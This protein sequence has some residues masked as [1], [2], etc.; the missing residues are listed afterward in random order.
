MDAKAQAHHEA[1]ITRA[2]MKL[3]AARR[4]KLDKLDFEAYVDG[5]KEFPAEAVEH[6]CDELGRIAPEEFQ[7]RFPAL[8]VVRER[9][10][11]RLSATSAKRALL[12]AAPIDERFPPLSPEK[13]EEILA[14]FRA[15]LRRRTMPN[16]DEP[17]QGRGPTKP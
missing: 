4:E 6:V 17:V 16:C 2:L 13:R 5:L 9:C 14:K 10:F 11:Q 8:Y 7:P 3:G 1:R 15:V 12:T